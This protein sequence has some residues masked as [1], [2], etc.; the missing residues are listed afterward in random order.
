[1]EI[2]M[3]FY[4]IFC[5]CSSVV[6]ACIFPLLL[7]F[8]LFYLCVPDIELCVFQYGGVEDSLSFAR[9]IGI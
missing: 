9:G 5:F 8:V 7:L 2:F 3:R 4:S 1:M 6:C